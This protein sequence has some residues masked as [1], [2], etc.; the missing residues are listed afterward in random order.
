ML[1]HTLTTDRSNM[2]DSRQVSLSVSFQ[3]NVRRSFNVNRYSSDYQRTERL[4]L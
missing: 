2:A 3:I 4:R 1:P